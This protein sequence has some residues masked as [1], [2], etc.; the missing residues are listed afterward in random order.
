MS[1]TL[2]IKCPR[3]NAVGKVTPDPAMSKFIGKAYFK[4]RWTRNGKPHSLDT[5]VK[6]ADLDD[7]L[8]GC[9]LD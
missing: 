8:F 1:K 2:E 6:Q 9:G 5:N 4:V 7:P 3:C